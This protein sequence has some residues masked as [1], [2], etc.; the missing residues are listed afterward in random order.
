MKLPA[1]TKLNRMKA[2]GRLGSA[3]RKLFA[4][5]KLQKRFWSQICILLPLVFDSNLACNVL[6]SS[7]PLRISWRIN[8]SVIYKNRKFFAPS[9]VVKLL[10]KH[11]CYQSGHMFKVRPS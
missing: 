3:L 6:R 1:T 10:A 2:V 4:D 9:I 5:N 11:L 7:G 8:I